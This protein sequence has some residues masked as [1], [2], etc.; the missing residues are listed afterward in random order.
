MET[1]FTADRVRYIAAVAHKASVIDGT[2]YLEAQE[3]A[4]MLDAFADLL[5]RPPQGWQPIETGPRDGS[6]FLGGY[7]HRIYGWLWDGARHYS[8]TGYILDSG[9]TP[10]HWQ[11]LPL[12]PTD[13]DTKETDQ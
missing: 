13:A 3:A 7:H 8:E 6:R 10:T 9:G 1:H 2:L 5:A 11:P 4:D 12:P